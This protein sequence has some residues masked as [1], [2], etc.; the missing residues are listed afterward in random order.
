MLVRCVICRVLLYRMTERSISVQF[1][2]YV[3]I[4]N[5]CERCMAEKKNQ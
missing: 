4:D 1:L 5:M 3:A 2:P